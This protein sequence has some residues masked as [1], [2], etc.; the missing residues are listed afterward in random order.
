MK[1][2]FLSPL[3]LGLL[4]LVLFSYACTP[5]S[6]TPT[7]LA[8]LD[9]LQAAPGHLNVALQEEEPETYAGLWI[10]QEPM[11]R[12]IVLF[13]RDGEK[14]LEPYI[15][16]SVLDGRVEVRQAKV[17]LAE[18]T[19]TEHDI[20]QMLGDLG[21]PFSTAVD[22]EE[23]QV[24]VYI[25]DQA[26]WES[27]LREKGLTLPDYVVSQVFYEPLRG[28]P[29]FS[30]TP[31]PGLFF[32]Q[33][34]A[35]SAVF[36]T[37][38]LEGQLI[39]ED[40]C[41]R[42]VTSYS[43]NSNLIIWQPDYFPTLNRDQIE[44]LNRDGQIVARV[45]EQ[46]AMGG[47]GIQLSDYYTRQLRESIPAICEGPYFLMGG[48]VSR[49]LTTPAVTETPAS[50]GAT[51]TQTPTS[52]HK[53]TATTTPAPTNTPVATAK[54]TPTVTGT[55]IV[56]NQVTICPGAPAISIKRNAWVQVSLHPPISNNVRSEPGLQGERIGRLK[57]GETVWIV[58]G[59]RCADG[60]TWWFVRSLAGLEGWTAEGDATGYWLRQPFDAF[61]YDTVN[62]SST[63]KVVLNEGQEYQII[64]SGTYSLWVPVQWTAQGVCILGESEL[65]PLFPSPLRWNGQVGADPFYQFARPF[66]GGCEN[67]TL[68][69][70]ETISAVMFSLDGGKS[71]SIPIPLIAKYR[72]DHTYIYEVNGQGYPL[73]VKLDDAVLD[74]NYGQILIV[75]EETK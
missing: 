36:M 29:G 12:V 35:Q 51:I 7:P 18:L 14:T 56:S 26:L 1:K 62:Q 24:I 6:L 58:D 67:R 38:L 72:E 63:S 13:T 2:R 32:P 40:G 31:V 11:L 33:L 42:V 45:G 61:F 75:I 41:L 19:S 50:R 16:G 23:N 43:P 27:T 21:L 71:Y 55:P 54:V 15:A 68:D 64:M 48:I 3:A 70:S 22:V 65:S 52:P 34:R 53:P 69:S 46:I 37:A 9:D 60:Y 28:E 73:K 74:D 39:L 5:P 8:N 17:S 20:Y 49:S 30:V 59:P 44:I 47:G 25:T 10:E 4:L 57:P 66:Y